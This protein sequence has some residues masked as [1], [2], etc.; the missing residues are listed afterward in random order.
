MGCAYKTPTLSSLQPAYPPC[1]KGNLV[2]RHEA[3]FLRYFWKSDTLFLG[4]PVSTIKFKLL[5]ESFYKTKTSLYKIIL[6]LLLN[7]Q[8]GEYNEQTIDDRS[9]N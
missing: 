8:M 2:V 3:F 1:I 6:R 5:H 4:I 7:N 9:K